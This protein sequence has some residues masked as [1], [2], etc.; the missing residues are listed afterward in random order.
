MPT[1]TMSECAQTIFS[2]RTAA[3]RKITNIC[4]R[5]DQ[6]KHVNDANQT[7]HDLRQN[8]TV[9][10]ACFQEL[11]EKCISILETAESGQR[12]MTLT[13]R[14]ISEDIAASEEYVTAADEFMFETGRYIEM[15]PIPHTT[16]AIPATVKSHRI[17]FRPMTHDDCHLWFMQLEDVFSSQGITSQITKFAALTTLLTEDEAYVVRDLTL[18]GDDRPMDVFD[19]AKRL[20]I[21]QYELTVHQRLSQAFAMGGIQADEKPS[22][23]MARFRHTGGEWDREDVERWALIRQL[24]TALHTTLEVPTPQLTM[25]ELLNKAD[26]LFATLARDTV[27]SVDT[28]IG[29]A[30]FAGTRVKRRVVSNESDKHNPVK[31]KQLCWYHR[32][33]GD[34]ARFCNG[35]PCPRYH[36]SLPK[37][38]TTES[39]NAEGN[40]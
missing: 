23:W 18:M 40:P 13:K 36:P 27:A 38:R 22:Q 1:V 33:F 24:P 34:K 14:S 12:E 10:L 6:I 7:V 39:G 32:K 20:F 3:K 2:R 37:G 26:D 29:A 21:H 5:F 19:E 25:N 30:V 35:P 17:S 31:S 9:T 28:N 8:M 15:N 16:N 11:D 4:K